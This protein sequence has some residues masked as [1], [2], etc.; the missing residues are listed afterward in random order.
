[1]LVVIAATAVGCGAPAESPS[2][3]DGGSTQPPAEQSSSVVSEDLVQPDDFEYLGAFRLPEDAERPRAFAYGGEAMTFNPAGDPDGADDGYPGSLYV[4]GHP[5]L[6][7]GE[8]PDGSQVAEISIPTPVIADS[9]SELD[10]ASFVQGFADVAAGR[11]AGLDEIPRAGMEYLDRPET[12]PRVHLSWGQHL[13][14]DSA[15]DVASH[16]YFSPDLSAPDMQGP[17]FIGDQSPHSVND[18]LFE[19]PAEWAERYVEGR[20]L[21]TGRYRDGGWGGMGPQLF[22]YTPWTD[23]DA[24]AACA[25]TSRGDSL[26]RVREVR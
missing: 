1:M 15:T 8:L 24:P 17:W 13:Q 26:A 18:Y 3:S 9:A 11:F 20:P 23:G 4:M 22:A 14:D 2:G 25:D 10:Q 21:A 5:R 19:I 12:G 16:A 7:Y 6:A